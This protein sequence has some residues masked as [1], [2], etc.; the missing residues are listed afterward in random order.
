MHKP[1]ATLE[2]CGTQIEESHVAMPEEL[3]RREGGTMKFA[4]ATG[5]RP[6][7]GYTIKRGIGVGGFGEVYFA[8][9]DAGKEVAIKR[10]QRNMDVEVRGVTQCLNLK[11]PNLL[12]LFDIKYDDEGQAWVVM[13]YVRGDSLKDVLDRNPNG[14]PISDVYDWIRGIAAGVAYLHDHGIVHRDM[15]PGNIFTDGDVVKIGDYG[16]SKYISCSRRSGQ[17]ESVGTFHYMAPEIGKGIY[18][19]EIDIYALGIIL[20]EMFTGRVPFE[21][22]SSQEIIMKHLTAEPDLSPIPKAF[23]PVIQ[24]C[25]FKDPEQR[26]NSVTEMMAEVEVACGLAPARSVAAAPKPPVVKQAADKSGSL[27]IGADEIETDDMYFGPLQDVVPA[28]TVKATPFRPHTH[29]SDSEPIADAVRT[30]FDRTTT[31]WHESNLTSPIKVLLLVCAVFLLVLNSTWL[32]PAAII[33]GAVYLMYYGIRST[34][35]ALDSSTGSP[36]ADST[37]AGGQLG[38]SA[39][40]GFRKTRHRKNWRLVARKQLKNKHKG[41][42]ISELSGSLLLSAFVS[43]VLCFVMM[44]VTHSDSLNDVF[45]WTSYAW[46]SMSAIAGAWMLLTISKVWESGE[47]E[48]FRRRFVMLIAGLATG[49]AAFSSGQFLG[50]R[51]TDELIVPSLPNLD[52]IG[53]LAA[54]EDSLTAFLVYFAGLFVILRWWRQTDP[55]R[56]S[57]VSFGRPP[58]A[59]CGPGSCTSSGR[60]RSRGDS[61]WQQRSR[62]RC[63]WRRRG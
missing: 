28:K 13:E 21:G 57:R 47:G 58:A 8:L 36:A 54:G 33:L 12:S 39:E 25:L 41:E 2:A 18:G 22:E 3:T 46:M 43:F 40:P 7:E 11:H 10:I 42:W 26:F 50:V 38:S 15:K 5:A 14:M 48:E 51:V 23:R 30:G 19:K 9:S 61:C 62:S 16:L 59:Y 53:S 35:L 24:R 1:A 37:F 56:E 4:Y 20:F 44:L 60:F 49:L 45:T 29:R 52:L 55:L 34:V 17:T 63:S 6:L 31:W 27:Y 32:V